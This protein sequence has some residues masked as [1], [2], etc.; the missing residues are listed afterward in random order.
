[1]QF[2]HDN[3]VSRGRQMITNIIARGTARGEFRALDPEVGARMF[4]ALSIMHTQWCSRR[5]FFPTLVER[6]DDDVR[7]ELFDF[8]MHALRPDSSTVAPISPLAAAPS[9]PLSTPASQ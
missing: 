5:Q 2:Y 3:V 7:D 1:M 8:F 6:T 9:S 4:S